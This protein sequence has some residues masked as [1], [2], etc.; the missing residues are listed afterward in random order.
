MVHV[1]FE[2]IYSLKAYTFHPYTFLFQAHTED[3]SFLG[4]AVQTPSVP[5][6]KENYGVV[7]GKESHY[8]RVGLVHIH[9]LILNAHRDIGRNII[10]LTFRL[11]KSWSVIF[12][13]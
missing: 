10:G 4:F 1:H 13:F 9:A 12:L 8:F 5:V 6:K 7:Y 3:N 11:F 2:H